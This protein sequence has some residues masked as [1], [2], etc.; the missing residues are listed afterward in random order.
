LETRTDNE[1]RAFTSSFEAGTDSLLSVDAV[2]VGEDDALA[3]REEDEPTTAG[4]K[5]PRATT[6]KPA[7]LTAVTALALIMPSS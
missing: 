2:G 6:T 5:I 1:E 4:A 3:G 7:P